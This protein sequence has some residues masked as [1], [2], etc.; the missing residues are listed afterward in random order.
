MRT[1]VTRTRMQLIE[2]N[3]KR[4]YGVIYIPLEPVTCL[5]LIKTLK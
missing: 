5:V 1:I 3:L 4:S 2:N